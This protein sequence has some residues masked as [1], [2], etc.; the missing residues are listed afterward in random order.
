M[1]SANKLRFTPRCV[2]ALCAG[3]LSPPK[4]YTQR[5]TLARDRLW[6][7]PRAH[8]FY[9]YSEQIHFLIMCKVCLC[10]CAA[11]P[12]RTQAHTDNTTTRTR[13]INNNNNFT[14]YTVFITQLRLDLDYGFLYVCVCLFVDA[15]HVTTKKWTHIHKHTEMMNDFDQKFKVICSPRGYVASLLNVWPC[16]GDWNLE[17]ELWKE[18]NIF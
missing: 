6:Y 2:R 8:A 12:G 9:L 16:A 3:I 13:A 10:V 17:I 18:K 11:R 4:I 5:C 14:M 1:I 15:L 7:V